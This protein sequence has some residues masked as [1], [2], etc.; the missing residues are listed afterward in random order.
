[1]TMATITIGEIVNI[2]I[3]HPELRDMGFSQVTKFMA[4][5]QRHID[6]IDEDARQLPPPSTAILSLGEPATQFSD[7]FLTILIVELG[8]SKARIH[9][10]WR[11]LEPVI[12]S[13]A[14]MDR[15]QKPSGSIYDW[16][17]KHGT[18]ESAFQQFPT[19]GPC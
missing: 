13:N 15:G 17:T 14:A 5:C 6:Q 18:S 12:R 16:F 11:A 7:K 19:I 1:M 4:L 9:Q 3:A 2:I 10:C 8:L